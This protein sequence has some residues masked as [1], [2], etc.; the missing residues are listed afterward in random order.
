[1]EQDSDFGEALINKLLEEGRPEDLPFIEIIRKMRRR[2]LRIAREERIIHYGE[3][4]QKAGILVQAWMFRNIHIEGS[5]KRNRQTLLAAMGRLRQLGVSVSDFRRATQI[6]SHEG[7][8]R[9]YAFASAKEVAECLKYPKEWAAF[10]TDILDILSHLLTDL[11]GCNSLQEILENE[12][13]GNFLVDGSMGL[14]SPEL[15]LEKQVRAVL[16][17]RPQNNREKGKVDGDQEPKENVGAS[18]SGNKPTLDNKI[19]S[20]ETETSN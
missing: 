6:V 18:G 14:P 3:Q 10:D 2:S 1:M 12:E 7:H 16:A 4:S 8:V 17:T 19:H 9:R 5:C 15:E 11:V 20:R 13:F